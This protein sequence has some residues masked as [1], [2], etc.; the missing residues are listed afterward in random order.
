MKKIR[1]LVFYR[2]TIF[3]SSSMKIP[4]LVSSMKRWCL[5]IFYKNTNFWSSV[6][7]PHSCLLWDDH[8]FW[9]S[10]S[11]LLPWDNHLLVFFYEEK[12]IWSFLWKF[13]FGKTTFW[14]SSNRRQLLV[15][16]SQAAGRLWKAFCW[17]AMEDNMLAVFGT[18]PAGRLLK[19]NHQVF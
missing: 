5:L 19:D 7:R 14:F 15:F 6:R 17:S 13:L 10:S 12:H 16:F 18:P 2:N 9:S 1:F 11:V 3:W 4:P 8:L